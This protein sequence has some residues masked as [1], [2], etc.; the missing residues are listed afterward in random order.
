[1]R[2]GIALCTLHHSA[3]D[4]HLIA[5]RPDYRIEVREDVLRESDGPMLIHGLQGFHQQQIRVPRSRR[6]V[7]RDRCGLTAVD[8]RSPMA[9][10]TVDVRTS[11][12]LVPIA[13]G[14]RR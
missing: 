1:V 4:A 13:P 5:V 7:K 6:F 14:E 3:F 2:N 9:R 12:H 8:Y 10:N 11:G